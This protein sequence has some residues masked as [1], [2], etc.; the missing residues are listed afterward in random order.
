MNKFVLLVAIAGSFPIYGCDPCLG[1]GFLD[2]TSP[3]SFKV[4]SK[5]TG[6]DLVFGQNPTYERDSVY[7]FTTLPGYSGRTSLI[8]SN[9]FTSTLTIP[10]D[11]FFLHFSP[12]E[13]DTLLMSYVYG[14]NY[15]CRY[16]TGY[17]RL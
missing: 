9:K 13:I 5:S 7:L 14:R 10:A 2:C 17:G 4:I 3:F 6:E 11:T 1:T 12:S 8:D 16:P 15:C